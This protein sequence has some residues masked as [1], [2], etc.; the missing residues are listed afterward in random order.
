MLHRTDL[1]LTRTVRKSDGTGSRWALQMIAVTVDA[2]TMRDTL[3]SFHPLIV[4]NRSKIG[5][6]VSS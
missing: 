3:R 4:N 2:Q 5:E 6:N 1:A